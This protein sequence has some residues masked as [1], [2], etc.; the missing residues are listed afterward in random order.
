MPRSLRLPIAVALLLLLQGCALMP[1]ELNLTPIWFHRLDAKGNFLE[2]DAAWPI[3]HYERTADG[4]DDFRIRPFYR[5]LTEPSPELPE[6]E[7]VEHQFLWPL[8]RVRSYPDETSARLFPLFSWRSR[9]NQD[10]FRDVDWYALF[11]F[12]WGGGSEDGE[13][14]FAFLPFYAD[15]PQFL[16]YTRFQTILFPLWV[17]LEKNDH[18]HQLA[19]WPFIAW[20]DCAPGTHSWF[21]V[22]PFYMHDIEE[23]RH[24]RYAALWPFF[25]WGT[26]N[27]DARSG[28]VDRFW[29][30]PFFGWQS[31]AEVSGWSALWPF[32]SAVN[33]RD[34]L[35]RLVLLWPFFQYY[36]NRVEDN[37]TRW[38]FWPFYSEVKS[39]DQDG[40]TALWPLIWWR[41]YRGPDDVNSQQWVLP[42]FWRVAIDR[43]NGH[44]ERHL[45]LWPL[46]HHSYEE[47]ETGRVVKSD[48][49]LLSPLWGRGSLTRG[50]QEA[51]GFLWE[52]ARSVQRGPNDKALDVAGRLYTQRSREDG[53]TASVPFLFNYEEDEHG[54]RTLRLFQ[55]LPIPFGSSSSSS[56]STETNN[57]A[58]TP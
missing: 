43:E 37:I 18:Y 13:D 25:T 32:F 41:T 14:Y 11:P 29:F 56:K 17:G 24:E 9:I 7:A 4:G 57:G 19:L 3:L 51:Y 22:L 45:K 26:E 20:S 33:K 39:D 55:F 49:S 40:W 12:L 34:H 36:W 38:W 53:T 58:K 52:I 44:K 46:A 28:P 15:I 27:K 50:L 47:D 21:R 16:T 42:F 54:D 31:G 23:G 10:G 1:R 35:T 6:D 48:W 2:W 30:W 5:R 8:G